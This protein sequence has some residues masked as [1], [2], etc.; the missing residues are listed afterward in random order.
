[1]YEDIK[2]RLNSENS[3]C[4]SVQNILSSRFLSMSIK[5]KT[6]RTMT[7]LLFCIGIKLGSSIYGKNAG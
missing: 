4:H 2:S 1:M 3:Y 6:H 5:I 7:C